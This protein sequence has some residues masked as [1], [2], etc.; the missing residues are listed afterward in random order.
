MTAQDIASYL[1]DLSKET[2][3]PLTNIK[4]QKLVYY[5][6][7]W[8]LVRFG[9]K[10]FEEPIVAWKYGPVVVSLYKEYSEFGADII[11]KAPSGDSN[12]I[13]VEAKSIIDDV[14]TIYGKLGGLELANL[15]HSERPWQET[16]E[17]GKEKQISDELIM[18]FYKAKEER[19][20][21]VASV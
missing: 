1:L 10:L 6:Y 11:K 7:V 20:S 12:N 5:S 15:T 13:T 14:F 9:G 16:F 18:E 19:V 17:E 4:L 21:S 8:F 3:E 2:G